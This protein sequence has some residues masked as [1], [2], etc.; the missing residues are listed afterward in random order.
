MI[1]ALA[2][3]GCMAAWYVG[4]RVMH[5]GRAKSPAVSS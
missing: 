4:V 2:W 3:G 1:L 5:K